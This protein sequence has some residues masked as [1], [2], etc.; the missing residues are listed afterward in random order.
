MKQGW[1]KMSRDILSDDVLFRDNEHLVVW[2]FLCAKAEYQPKEIK[3]GSSTLTLQPGQLS[4]SR[5]AVAE[6]CGVNESKV[7]RILSLFE[8]EQKIKQVKLARNR[9]I[10]VLDA[11]EQEPEDRMFE[12]VSN[13]GCTSVAQPVNTRKKE[14]KEENQNVNTY[15]RRGAREGRS[16]NEKWKRNQPGV[17]DSDASYDLEAFRQ[18]SLNRIINYVPK[19]DHMPPESENHIFPGPLTDR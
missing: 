8:S 14:K 4:T 10:T 3:S 16:G 9:L 15:A 1:F 18:Y 7:E 19:Y 5:R 6:A 12:Q 13:D 2:C 17:Y 11:A